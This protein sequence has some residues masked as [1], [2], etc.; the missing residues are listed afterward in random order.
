MS[1]YKLFATTPKAMETLLTEELQSLGITQIKATM[2]G[3]AF[4]GDLETAY[5]ACLWSRTANRILLVLSSF[6]VKSQEDLYNGIQEIDWFEHMNPDDTFAVSFSAKNSEAINNT[7]FGALKVKDAIVDQMRERFQQ[8]PS[9]DT[10]QPSIRINV[11][12]QG[13]LAQLSL[14]LSGESL[15]RRGYRDVNIKAPMKENLA[16]AMLLRCG[17]PQIAKQQGTLIDPMCGSGTLLLEGAMIAADYAPGL[18]RD[19]FGFIGWKK[20]DALCWKKLLTEAQQR[21]KIGIETLPIIVG[22]D[23]NRQTVNT[24]LAHIVNAGLQHKI[25]VERRDIEDASPASSW[26][27]GL[28]ICNP[29]YGER[30]GTEQETSDLYKRFGESL[31]AHFVGWK[32]AMIISNP[33]LGFRLGI[34]SQKPITLFNGAL[35]CKLLRL[36]IEESSFFIPKAKTQEDRITQALDIDSTEHV[37]AIGADMFANRLTKNLKKFSRW[38]KQQNISCYRVYDADLPEYAVAIDIYQGDQTWINIQEYEPPKSIDQHKADQRL[39]ALLAEIPKVLNVTR[40]QVFLKIRKKQRSTDQ[41]E[42]QAE[43]GQFHTIEE[44][45]CKLLVNFEDYLDTGLFLDHRPIRMLIQK[46]A[47][48]KRFL[49]LF[50]Y[51]GSASVHA[52]MGGAKA[53]TTVDMSNTYIAWAKNN[54]ALNKN[55]GEHEFIQADCLDW[56]AVAAKQ[57]NKPQYDLIFLDPPTFSNSKR[58]TDVFDIQNDHVSLINNAASLLAPNGVLYFSTNFRRFKIDLEALADLKIVDISKDTIPEDFARNQRIHYC[59]SIQRAD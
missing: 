36:N 31:K 39:A 16:A 43:L 32:A 11:Y 19:Y 3:V 37:E 18:L 57:E 56:L 20:H 38:A 55:S 41:Y 24:A 23:Q 8:R 17:W 51:T 4:E 22:F 29:P 45:G 10:A 35:E 7:H 33:E 49:N 40:E 46:Q 59:W 28:L 44:G 14:D 47:K 12:L 30:L 50:A 34:R 53:T 9:I 42:K 6:Q 5:R 13:E 52:A 2:A 26:K 48:D 58:M 21:K 54:M 27:P 1:T 15:H 25:H